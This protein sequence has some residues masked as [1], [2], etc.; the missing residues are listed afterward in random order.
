MKKIK[1]NQYNFLIKQVLPKCLNLG[2]KE[3]ARKAHTKGCHIFNTKFGAVLPVV[4]DVH[5]RHPGDLPHPSLQIS[6]H[7]SQDITLVLW[8]YVYVIKCQNY[9]VLHDIHF[10]TYSKTPVGHKEYHNGGYELSLFT[11]AVCFRLCVCSHKKSR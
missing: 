5:D 9:T 10:S 11:Q 1:Q 3:Y 8:K 6:V 4:W 2:K 7:S